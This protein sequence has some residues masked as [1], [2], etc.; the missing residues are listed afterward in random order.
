MMPFYALRSLGRASQ[1]RDAVLASC[2]SISHQ[3]F[4][5]ASKVHPL[6]LGKAERWIVAYGLMQSA[7]NTCITV[8][9][10]AEAEVRPI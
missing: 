9:E 8:F 4:G 10:V 5:P 6:S 1:N 3:R 7:K 2:L